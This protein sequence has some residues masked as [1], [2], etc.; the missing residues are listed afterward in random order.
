M[1]CKILIYKDNKFYKE[2]SLKKINNGNYIYKWSGIEAGSYF[3]ELKDE[4]GDVSSITYSHT[5]PFVTD[6]E[7]V[8]EKN[9]P[10][11]SI[12]GFQKGIDI[13]VTYIPDKKLFILSK[14]KFF[15]MKLDIADFGLERPETVQISGNFNNWN[16]EEEPVHHLSGTIYEIVLAIPEGVYEYKY[17]IDNKWY[18]ENE[19]KK[20]IIGENGALFHKGDLG[21]GKFVYEAI[22]KNTDLKAIVHNHKSPL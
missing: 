19:N 9:T 4:N 7:A 15:R 20:L 21:T 5:A 6:F 17:L 1:S 3:F 8:V 18:P 2:E 10:P 13:L 16:A 12:T 14:K 11:K 22:D